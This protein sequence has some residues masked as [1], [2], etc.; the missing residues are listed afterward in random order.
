MQELSLIIEPKSTFQATSLTSVLSK[1]HISD[2]ARTNG[3]IVRERLFSLS[4]YLLNAANLMCSS[5]KKSEFTLCSLHD[6]YNRLNPEKSMSHKC[7]HKQLQ[8]EKTLDVM[9]S[10]LSEIMTLPSASSFIKKIKKALPENLSKLLKQLKVNDIILIDGT[11]IDLSYSCANNFYC[12]GKGRPHL[13][14]TTARPGLKLHIAFSMVKQT[15]EYFEI[16]EAVGSERACVY[17]EK[18]KNTLIIAD[19]GYIDEELEQ[20]IADSGNFFLI[21][22]RNNTTGIIN[23]AYS[24]SGEELSNLIDKTIKDLPLTTNADLTIKTTKGN[25]LRVVI[26]HHNKDEESETRS[27][28]RTNI[29]KDR[30][31]ARQIYL[32]YRIRWSIELFNKANKQSSCLQSINSANKNIILLFILL[33]LMVSFIKTYLGHKARINNKIEWLSMLKLHNLNFGFN[34]LFQSL[35]NKGLSTVYQIVKELLDDIALYCKR[36]KPSNRD[37]VLF[38]DLPML[39]WQIVN[40]N[41][42]HAKSA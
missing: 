38:K 24:D 20:R 1:D 35:Q 18:F 2:L 11:E 16:T 5:T 14:G 10:L 27:V 31:C 30:L 22:G 29:P 25:N 37:S 7:I 6:S 26:R 40:T 12:K 32:L 36:S 9:K 34:K 13:D 39:L 17:P 33:S 8:N 23:S 21:R 4:D 41:R 28:L 15:F 19:R 42:P 3:A